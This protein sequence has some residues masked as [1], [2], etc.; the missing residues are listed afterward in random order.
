MKY[1]SYLLIQTG[2]NL[3]QTWDAQF[4]TLFTVSLSV[5]I[6]AFFFLVYTN[7][8]KAG[9]KLGNE[10]RLIVYLQEEIIPEMLPS[11]EQKI[12][13]FAEVEKIEYV[14]REQAYDRLLNQLDADKDVLEDLGPSFLPPSI[15]VYPYK[16]LKNLAKIKQFSDYL[17]T[18][19]GATKIQ[20]G[21]SWLER[22]SYFTQLLRIIMFLSGILLVLTTTFMVAYTIRLTLF[23]RQEE[24]QILRLLGAS[25]SYIKGPLLIEGLL[26][27]AVGALIGLMALYYLYQWVINHFSGPGFLNIFD[28]NFFPATVLAS[29]LT[30]SIILCICGSMASIRKF[31]RV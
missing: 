3:K 10:I 1:L 8:M 2:R 28:L 20:Y 15:E 21:H 11:I 30:A 13:D 26:Q 27:G 23:A 12:R 16:D 9:D 25:S 14:N 7:V 5:L 22:F 19:P 18:L 6:F 24:L 29:I 4:M 31:L 17:A